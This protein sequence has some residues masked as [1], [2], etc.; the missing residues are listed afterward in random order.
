MKIIDA[1]KLPTEAQQQIRN[2]AIHLKKSGKT[3]DEV[4][5]ITSVHKSTI[6]RWYKAYQLKGTNA[7]QI[8]K[9]G[10]R[11]GSCRTLTVEMEKQ[12]QKTIYSNTPCFINLFI[13]IY[14][15]VCFL[16]LS[17]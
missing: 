13:C 8:K 9:R 3:Y 11:N 16:F 15:C 6:V 17:T 10:R 1:R 5:D 14:L 4:S 2:Q 12:I 7:I